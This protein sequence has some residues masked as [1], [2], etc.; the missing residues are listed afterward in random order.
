MTV[1]RRR[2]FMKILGAG[3]AAMA[4]TRSLSAAAAKGPAKKGKTAEADK[5]PGGKHQPNPR[6][7]SAIKLAELPASGI[8]VLEG[9]TGKPDDEKWGVLGTYELV[10]PAYTKACSTRTPMATPPA[11]RT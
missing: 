4:L 1:A 7:I 5:A 2:D 11:G 9:F 8:K 6:V 10:L 3:A